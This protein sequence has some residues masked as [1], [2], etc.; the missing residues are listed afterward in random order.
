MKCHFTD[1][2]VYKA[3]LGCINERLFKAMEVGP[4]EMKPMLSKAREDTSEDKHDLYSEVDDDDFKA[5]ILFWVGFCFPYFIGTFILGVN[6]YFYFT[7]YRKHARGLKRRPDHVCCCGCASIACGYGIAS[8]V[9][10]FFHFL[11]DLRLFGVIE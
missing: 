5:R 10:L 11:F 4:E 8:A 9:L 3:L 7:A 1:D 2:L 6:T